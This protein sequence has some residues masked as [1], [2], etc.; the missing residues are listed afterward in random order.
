MDK[1]HPD[2]E[3]GAGVYLTPDINIAERF[4]GRILINK[5][6]YKVVLMAKVLIDKIREPE[7]INYWILDKEYIRFYRILVKESI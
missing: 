5:K 3:I 4:S 2:Q 1:R 7:D 6:K